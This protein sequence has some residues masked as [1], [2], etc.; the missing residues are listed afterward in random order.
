MRTI[1]I[2]SLPDGSFEEIYGYCKETNTV[3]EFHGNYYHSNPLMYNS[4]D[5]NPTNDNIWR[6]I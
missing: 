1:I 6:I 2:V 3:N 5:I 4:N